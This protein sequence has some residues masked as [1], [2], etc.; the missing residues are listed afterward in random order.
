M[1]VGDIFISVSVSSVIHILVCR[2]PSMGNKI[3]SSN[4]FI[5]W[6]YRVFAHICFHYYKFPFQ[7]VRDQ[8]ACIQVT[9]TITNVR[10]CAFLRLLWVISYITLR[11]GISYNIP[12]II[13]F[14]FKII[15]L[16]T[17]RGRIGSVRWDM[18]SMPSTYRWIILLVYTFKCRKNR[19]LNITGATPI[20]VNLMQ[21]F[22]SCLYVRACCGSLEDK[23]WQNDQEIG[24]LMYH[25]TLSVIK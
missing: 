6:C 25:V 12:D 10:L 11:S 24:R 13:K 20:W 3:L 9:I 21:A 23:L 7:I 1:K 16:L 14:F 8:I 4:L 17:V 5:T 15:K 18:F 2:S 22:F 19:N